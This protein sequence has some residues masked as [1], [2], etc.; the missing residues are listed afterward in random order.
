M[1]RS[2]VLLPADL[3]AQR[4]LMVCA[5]YCALR[6]YE[7]VAVVSTWRD[8]WK[9]VHQGRAT[10]LVIGRRDHLPPGFEP[11]LEVVTEQTTPTAPGRRRPQRRYVRRKV[12]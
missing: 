9:L 12:E 1:L 10:V 8:A 7:V 4:W 6:S 3:T 5:E 11:R 2:I